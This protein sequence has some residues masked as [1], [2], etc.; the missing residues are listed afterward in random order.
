MTEDQRKKR[1]HI[2]TDVFINRVY[3]AEGLD[4]SSDGMYLY[5]RHPYVEG[6]IID[7]SFKLGDIEIHGP[8]KVIHT[9]PGIGFGVHFTDLKEEDAEKIRDYVERLGSEQAKGAPPIKKRPLT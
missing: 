8:A 5:T 4:L 7:L 6:S 2:N 3:H 9:Q 1:L